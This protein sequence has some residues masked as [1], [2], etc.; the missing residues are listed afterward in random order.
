VQH[1]KQIF[2]RFSSMSRALRGGPYLAHFRPAELIR[3]RRADETGFG[4]TRFAIS[5]SMASR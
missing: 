3:P 2:V 5:A 1:D 4:P